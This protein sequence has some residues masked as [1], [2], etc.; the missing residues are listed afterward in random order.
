MAIFK[1]I[2]PD[3]IIHFAAESHVDQSIKSPEKF[4]YSNIIGTFNLLEAA[5]KHWNN[6]FSEK[7][8]HHISTDE[9]YGSLGKQGS[10]KET[11]AY[12]PTSPYSAS[13]ASSDHLVN[14]YNRTFKLPTSMSNC[15]NNYGINQHDEKLIPTVIRNAIQMKPIP[16]W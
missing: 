6:D 15:S 3:K 2:N 16:I 14:A 10:F 1:E 13:K 12:A 11:T 5:L 4:I 7:R 9:V 8:F